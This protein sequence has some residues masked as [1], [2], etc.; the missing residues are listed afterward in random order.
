MD[1]VEA[2]DVVDIPIPIQTLDALKSRRAESDSTGPQDR[3][4]PVREN[5]CLTLNDDL[6]AAGIPKIDVRG[7]V[8]DVHALR[9]T[10]V[11]NVYRAS[12]DLFLAQRFA[13]Q[14]AR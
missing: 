5:L 8:V 6:E 4:V 1:A 9:H 7:R 10:A 14:P 12:R 13:R 2:F 11:T 3:V